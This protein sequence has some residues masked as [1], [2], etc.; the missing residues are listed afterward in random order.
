MSF[1]L[2][3]LIFIL[4]FANSTLVFAQNQDSLATT[5]TPIDEPSP[6]FQAPTIPTIPTS[7][8]SGSFNCFDYYT[9]GSVQAD[10]HPGLEQTVP[11]TTLTFTGS[12]ISSN[13]YP[14]LDGTLYVKI[15]KQDEE[16]LSQGDGNQVVDQFV[17]K[18]NITL[19]AKGSLP[20]SYEWKVPA[21]A[22]NGEYYAA[23][24]FT[25]ANRY[26]LMGLSFTDD[27]VGNT[28]P[29]SI[30]SESEVVKLSKIDT[31][32]N[33]Q[34]NNFVAFPLHFNAGDTVMVKTTIIN[35]T[36]K[37][38]TV[39]LQWNQYAWDSMNQENLRF[40]KTEVV[41]L[42]AGETKTVTYEAQPQRES[43]VYIVAVTQDN[44]AKSILNVRYVRDGIEE[45]RINFPGVMSFPLAKDTENTLFACAHSTNAPLVS[46]NT[47]TLTLADKNGN[48][49]HQY[50]YEGDI[51]SAMAGFGETFSPAKNINYA[52]LT[53]TLERNGVIVEQVVQTYDCTTIDS[54]TCLPEEA[55]TTSLIDFLKANAV[56][57]LLSLFVLGGIWVAFVYRVRK[58]EHIDSS[59]TPLSLL[60]LL[61]LLPSLFLVNGG[62]VEAKS[63]VWT[64]TETNML[65]YLWNCNGSGCGSSAGSGW[66]IGMSPPQINVSYQADVYNHDTNTL[67]TDGSTVTVGTNLRFVPK[68]HSST[69]ITWF[70]HG[71]S[72]DSPYGYWINGA[73]A[74]A[75]GCNAGDQVATNVPVAGMGTVNVYVPLSVNPPTNSLNFTGS[76]ATLTP[77][78]GNVYRVDSNGVIKANFVFAPTYGEF[79]YR[80]RIS[81]KYYS[82]WVYNVGDCVGNQTAM[83]EITSIYYCTFLCGYPAYTLTLADYRLQV[84]EQIIDFT[85]NATG[86]NQPPNAP[87]I[88]GTNS[89]SPNTNYAFSFSATDPDGDTLRYGIDW[90]NNSTVDQWLPGSGYVNSGTSQSNN[91]LWTTSGTYTFQALTQDVNGVSSG[92]SN[93]SVT[94]AEAPPSAYTVDRGCGAVSL[95]T[96]M[97][98]MAGEEVRMD[99]AANERGWE[100]PTTSTLSCPMNPFS[101]T[102]Y[103]G[104]CVADAS[105]GAPVV[106][107]TINGSTGPLSVTRGSALNISWNTSFV[108][109][110][111]KF[112]ANWGSGQGIPLTGSETVSA[113]VSD[114]Y[115]INCNGV[116]DSVAVTVVNQAP[117]APT[118][119]HPSGSAPYN[120][121]T[122]FTIAGTDA[123]GDNVFYEVDWDNNGTADATTMT[124][125]SGA[126]Q[127]ATRSWTTTG[128]QTFQARTV[129]TVGARSGWT[130]HVINIQLPPAATAALEVQVNGGAWSATDQTVNPG[131]TVNLRWSSTNA[132]SCSGTGAGFATGNNPSGTDA[133]TTPA[134]NSATTFS[135]N[136]SGPGGSNS[137]SVSVTTRQSPNFTTPLITY[138]PLAFNTTNST[139]DS[140]EVIF[141]T[142]NN[143]GSDTTAS[144]NYQ[145]QFD[146]GS[147]GYDVTTNGSLG[148]LAVSASMNR[149]ETVTNVPLGNNRIRVTVDSTNAVSEVNEGDNVATLDI[150]IPPPNPGIDITAN[151][152]QVRSGETVT[153]TWTS[154]VVYTL[155]CRV[156]GPG[157]NVN[158]SGLSG[159]QLTQP[160]TAKSEFTLSCT[161]P[162]TGTVFTDSVTV[163]AQGEIEEI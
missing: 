45:T 8:A 62:E 138:N 84:P 4:V 68:T 63:V 48:T 28:A 69:D 143:G 60:F 42:A 76:T 55:P 80:Y 127:P 71:A 130:S 122:T 12:V 124:V 30:T 5:S 144:A 53:A 51:S 35:P 70:G 137:D 97:N 107:L 148:L 157:V 132:T 109:S 49:I 95:W 160:I 133:V 151:R 81:A 7:A 11:G 65:S 50:R 140:M 92:W 79:Y 142:S 106:N 90:D 31:T 40:T 47:L 94:I 2:R 85:F 128:A 44:E 43:V 131:D 112:G 56:I 57:I 129:D 9:F 149:T 73:A 26:N 16:S 3:G 89:G 161:E 158:P 33:G 1:I 96:G 52:T 104:I 93:H 150:V 82:N 108:P 91:R 103:R 134:P 110:C 105:C 83:Q 10:L 24:F 41:T 111:T 20:M 87:V 59:S 163:E 125:A 146:R 99:C 37:P 145:F 152:T 39:P 156:F 100:R 38:K 58:N 14:L 32:L 54:N 123:D 117:N 18:D 74:P 75:M 66:E 72:S 88:G 64:R 120:T 135:V 21:N 139:Y 154:A 162:V 61:I 6:N 114:T 23:Y 153:L 29:F 126:S 15:F 34:N 115:L 98:C 118:I 67:I 101:Y 17:I 136:C 78:S 141:Q 116:I 113:T 13:P 121:N 77:I 36:D 155:N 22:E 159:T 86:G 46:G 19:P 119:T 27:V 25:T 102:G 147:N